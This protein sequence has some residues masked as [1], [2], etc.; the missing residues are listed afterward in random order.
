M[1][2]RFR[3]GCGVPCYW[4]HLTGR[5]RTS[6]A[7]ASLRPWLGPSITSEQA[8][9]KLEAAFDFFERLRVPFSRSMTSMRWHRRTRSASTRKLARDRGPDRLAAWRARQR[10]AAVGHGEP[11][12]PS[13]VRGRCRHEPGPGGASP[14]PPGQVRLCLETT[15]RLGGEN[16]V[17]W[18]GREGYDTLLNTDLA[19]ELEPARRA[20]CT[21][22][23]STSTRSASAARS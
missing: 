5:A 13:A 10:T 19:R 12:Q 23:S 15:H 9:Q 2:S 22:S 18:G 4:H 21:W 6:S 8:T 14:T 11:V 7:P 17:L 3:N 16:Y 1:G 20:S